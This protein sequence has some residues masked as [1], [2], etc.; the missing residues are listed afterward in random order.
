MS[1]WHGT[2]ILPL[3]QTSTN[4]VVLHK[5]EKVIGIKVL[6]DP[7]RDLDKTMM[8]SILLRKYAINKWFC[9]YFL[10]S[11]ER[12][13]GVSLNFLHCTLRK[14]SGDSLSINQ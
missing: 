11:G 10:L 7:A 8:C 1:A 14:V 5:I 12:L 2:G 9:F 3:F 6:W 4:F 13:S